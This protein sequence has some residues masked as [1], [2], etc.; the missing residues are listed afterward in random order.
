MRFAPSGTAC[1]E[2][3]EVGTY[4]TGLTPCRV[5]LA[6][7]PTATTRTEYDFRFVAFGIRIQVAVV[8]TDRSSRVPSPHCTRYPVAPGTA[9]QAAL[10]CASPPTTVSAMVVAG[11]AAVAGA[12]ATAP[13]SA[14]KPTTAIACAT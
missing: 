2:V 3:M 12:A 7:T 6:A 4:G 5:L 9:S 1:T 11:G 14:A 13:A 8:A 10:I